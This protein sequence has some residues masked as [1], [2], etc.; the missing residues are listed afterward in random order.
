M[1]IRLILLA[2]AALA[3]TSITAMAADVSG[4]WTAEVEGRNGNKQTQ[5]FTFKADG[6]TLTGTMAGRGEPVNISD[7]K[8]DGDNISFSV[9][10]ERNG[11]T[12]KMNYTGKMSG[13][14]IAFKMGMEGN[15]TTRDF[16]AKR[17]A[18]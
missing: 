15:D 1:K 16:T 13:D 10:R 3:L 11:N 5:T 4:K 12:M 2:C 18:D 7:G 17:S 14:T 6:S 9:T 8:I